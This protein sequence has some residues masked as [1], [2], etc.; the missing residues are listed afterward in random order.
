MKKKNKQIRK[1]FEGI[2]KIILKLSDIKASFLK[3]SLEKKIFGLNTIPREKMA[4][5][6]MGNFF[7]GIIILT[8][9]NTML[10]F[11]LHLICLTLNMIIT[12]LIG[13]EYARTILFLDA[14]ILGNRYKSEYIELKGVYEQF[15]KKALHILNLVPCAIVL[16]IFFWGIFS[17]HYIK[18]DLVGFYAVCIVSV[19]VSISVIGY[20]QYLWLLWFLFRVS[21]CNFVPYNKIVPAYTP[22]LIQI[23]IL[24]KHGKWCF[25][26]EGFLYVFQYFILIPDGNVTSTS[27]KMPNTFSFLVTW[28]FIFVAI[29]L[30]FPV[31]ISAQEFLLSKIVSNLKS[32]RIEVL[33]APLYSLKSEDPEML[34]KIYICNYLINNSPNYPVKIQRL[35]PSAVAIATF[36]LHV[37]NLINQYPVLKTF[38]VNRFL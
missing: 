1:C 4:F 25:F 6:L 11:F 19:S 20:T 37:L 17:Q 24:T 28:G 8:Y 30:A 23:G 5:L 2:K 12:I 27:I 29:I 22:F 18:A 14:E 35:G 36:F 16:G 7:I 13:R 10:H 26:L 32:Q 15:R 9:T 34:S 3:I 21:R 38:L 31:I 33:S